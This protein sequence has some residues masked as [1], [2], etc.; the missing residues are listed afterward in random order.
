M[1]PFDLQKALAGAPVVTRDG[2]EISQLHRFNINSNEQKLH[3]VA[4]NGGGSETIYSW[5]DSG[6][7]LDDDNAILTNNHCC[8]LFMK[9]VKKTYWINF[10]NCKD[11]GIICV[12]RQIFDS[13]IN[14]ELNSN[15]GAIQVSFEMEE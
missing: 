3:G 7:Y 14:A 4:D 15:K 11:T 5:S 8:D 6:K 10:Y 2:R 13:Q 1:K 12:G 9:T